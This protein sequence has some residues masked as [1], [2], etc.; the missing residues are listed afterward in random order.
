MNS[1]RLLIT[2]R[3]EDIA[4]RLDSV[5]KDMLSLAS[6]W[7]DGRSE[8]LGAAI[9]VQDAYQ[10]VSRRIKMFSDLTRKSEENLWED[11]PHEIPG[12]GLPD[13]KE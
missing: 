7:T 11:G 13:K 5:C 1:N 9:N 10:I 12:R 3:H 2:E 6:D 4:Q 8:L